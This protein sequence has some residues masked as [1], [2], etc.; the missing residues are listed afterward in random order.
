MPA[1]MYDPDKPI[2]KD[3]QWQGPRDRLLHAIEGTVDDLGSTPRDRL[4]DVLMRRVRA[5]A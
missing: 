2:L 1:R 5:A 4:F 3:P